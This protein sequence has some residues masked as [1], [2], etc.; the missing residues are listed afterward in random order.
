MNGPAKPEQA[1]S[2]DLLDRIPKVMRERLNQN[3][4]DL[5]VLLQSYVGEFC[6]SYPVRHNGKLTMVPRFG[7]LSELAAKTPFIVYDLPSLCRKYKT[8]M[9]DGIRVYF[10]AYFLKALLKD[11]E[12]IQA[13]MKDV[14]LKHLKSKAVGS[15][16]GAL[17]KNAIDGSPLIDPVEFLISHELEHMRRLHLQ[18]MMDEALQSVANEAQDTRINGD[19]LMVSMSEWLLKNNLARI[20]EID[21]L[22]SS[23]TLYKEL[24]DTYLD[25]VNEL[26]E[27]IHA[28]CGV[29]K[30]AVTKYWMK[31][32][33]EIGAMLL[34]ENKGVPPKQNPPPQKI[35]FNDLCVAVSEDLADIS[36]H[37]AAAPSPDSQLAGLL[38]PK[39]VDLGQKKGNAPNLDRL[40]DE[41]FQIAVS[42]ELPLRNARHES[43]VASGGQS[44][45][46]KDLYIAQQAPSDRLE[47]LMTILDMKLNPSNAQGGNDDGMQIEGID[48]P[49]G[50]KVKDPQNGGT[51]NPGS[52]NDHVTTP[53]ELAKLLEEA[54]LDKTKKALGYDDLKDIG[55]QMAEAKG[56]TSEAIDRSAETLAAC[57]NV[58]PGGH[59]TTYAMEKKRQFFEPVISWRMPMKDIIQGGGK[60]M[61]YDQLEASSSTLSAMAYPGD[62]GYES[63]DDV[64]WIGSHIPG[65]RERGFVAVIEDTSG[66]VSDRMLQRFTSEAINMARENEDDSAPDVVICMAD[67]V[68]RGDPVFVTPENYEE[69]LLDGVY[70]GGRGGTNL[71]AA[72]QN[73]FAWTEEGG[74]MEG[75]RLDGVVYFT[76][77]LDTPPA[78][79]DV[80][81]ALPEHMEELPPILYLAPIECTNERFAKSVSDYAECV[82]FNEKLGLEVDLDEV[83]EKTRRPSMV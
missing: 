79:D 38:A 18:R 47:L 65:K 35:N 29:T 31:S 71:T 69:I 64:G 8:A 16:Y 36:S 75:R 74:P 24:L 1:L 40:L 55:S 81:Q 73:V 26:S 83:R 43:I 19:I 21:Q 51:G 50:G 77:T 80:E 76:D 82:F 15:G 30:E 49:G 37:H 20:A 53:E 12:N 45:S 57:G 66:S 44:V 6:Q 34:K 52:S 3:H 59:L 7:M 70:V 27:V 72:I 41:L 78:R 25:A 68:C 28:G 4:G 54:G 11:I 10:N 60:A 39:V 32:E 48:L 46:V 63:M 67:T 61:Q 62:F 5:Q 22:F 17:I 14:V 58:M 23:T 2:R 56:M 33:E 42:A 9:T 13:K